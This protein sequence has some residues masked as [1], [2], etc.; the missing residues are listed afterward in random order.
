MVH[1]HRH[2][3]PTGGQV[4]ID[5]EALRCMA[6]GHRHREY[7]IWDCSC[8]GIEQP[9]YT[10]RHDT[11][12]AQEE[13]R[14]GNLSAREVLQERCD[15]TVHSRGERDGPFFPMVCIKVYR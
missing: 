2:R 13:A 12:L 10:M 15:S 6:H 3:K 5:V 9:Q 7:D 14:L 11:D 1:G 4:L 8:A